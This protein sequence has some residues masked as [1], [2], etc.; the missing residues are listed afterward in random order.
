M[1]LATLSAL[2]P[3]EFSD[4]ADGYRSTSDMASTAKDRIE[5][6]ITVAM[7][8]ANEG[9]A[10][11]AGMKQLRDLAE[12]FH[13]TQVECGL[14]AAALNGFAY[15]LEAA[16]K[17]LD[18]AV[19]GAQAEK[20]TVNP[21]GSIT[22][23]ASGEQVDGKVPQGGTVS[24]LPDG[25]AAAIGHQAANVDP[26]PNHR[27]AL[28]Y[29]DLIAD[30]LQQAT[31]AD[32]KWA[33]KLR[34]L[35]ADD[36]L[37]VSDRDWSDVKKDTAGVLKG[38][39]DY[40]DS[41][42]EPPKHG[43]P[44]DNAQWWKSL[45]DEQ[46]ADYIAVHPDS[47]GWMDGLPAAVRDEANRTVLAE[48]RGVAQGELNAWMAKEPKPAYY[49]REIINA[50]TGERWTAKIPT[51]EWREWEKKRKELQSPIDAMD[52]I[53]DRYDNYAGDE[54]TRP[55]LL[56]F[57]NKK[58]GHVV[59]SIGN[60]DTADNVVTYVPGTGTKLISIDGDISRAELLQDQATIADPLH[61]TA[62]I[63]WLG[64]DAPQSLMGDATDAKWA[65]NAR[66]PLNSFL[67][68]LDT[69]HRGGHANSTIMG[70]S[71]GT[72]VAGETM[73][74]H[75]DL[76]VDNAILVGSPGVGVN[77]A[78]DLNIPAD[79]VW[80]ATAKNDLV[81][82]AP[83]PAG[84]L[85][86][87]NPKAYMRLFDDHSIMYG[88]DPTSDEFGGRTF[89]VADGKFPGADGFMPAH[90]QYWEGDSLADMAKIATGGTP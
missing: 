15:D 40:L 2:K 82:V 16:K 18:A 44:E 51:E 52:A 23:P 85:A 50:Q 9:E 77:H 47:I 41:I 7:R 3:S 83:P 67:T 64:Y 59:M 70:H 79:H 30:A 54:S 65:D 28:D 26:N 55:Y 72:L 75:P 11:T 84:M 87:L 35:K 60:P 29:V 10:A 73:R 78:K 14:V 80:A 1:D 17:K 5:H 53:Q 4:A 38:A 19:E 43:T 42:K 89:R 27:R 58:L 62:S 56:G 12:N 32:E 69:A 13:Y 22:Y 25:T 57:D 68:G 86:P 76:P 45:T 39:E 6:Q 33:P 66:E 34:A 31:E 63:M 46:R 21:D 90:S 71:Y 48:A 88:N 81:N 24:S 8:Q 74:D 20:F 49:E 37:T 36:D 61:S